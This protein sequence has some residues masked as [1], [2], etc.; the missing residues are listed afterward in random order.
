MD[1]AGGGKSWGDI[2]WSVAP[3]STAEAGKS[4]K[5]PSCR[6]INEWARARCLACDSAAPHA[7]Q[8]PK[9]APVPA[10]VPTTSVFQFGGAPAAVSASN[11]SPSPSFFGS[12]PASSSAPMTFTFGTTSVVVPPK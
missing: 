7:D 5:C 6:I 1:Q 11:G 10:V 12:A 4:W 8:L 9:P 2:K 3:T